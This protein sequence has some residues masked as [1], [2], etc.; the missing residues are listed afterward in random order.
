MDTK[1]SPELPY[2]KGEVLEQENVSLKDSDAFSIT[3]AARGDNLP[4]SECG[5][6]INRET[7][8]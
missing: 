3:D 4:D 5:G 2:E 7:L 8:N 6:M 1:S